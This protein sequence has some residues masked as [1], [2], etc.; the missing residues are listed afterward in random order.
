MSNDF[1]TCNK[2]IQGTLFEWYQFGHCNYDYT[3]SII[4]V[5]LDFLNII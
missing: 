2:T 1:V 4:T 5:Y 3:V